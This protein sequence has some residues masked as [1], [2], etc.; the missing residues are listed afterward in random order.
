MK[1]WYGVL[2]GHRVRLHQNIDRAI[3]E[4]AA[5]MRPTLTI[6]DATRILVAN[7]P[8]GG[9]LDDVQRKDTIAA[10]CDEVAL[11]AFGATLLGLSANDLGYV[12]LASAA[13]LGERDLSRLKVEEISG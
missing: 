6:L 8:S 12:G 1:N 7:G 10:S 3:F 4:L 11:D 5:M 2:G 9:S 13:R